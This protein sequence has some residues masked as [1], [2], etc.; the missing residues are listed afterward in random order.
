MEIAACVYAQLALG[1][2]YLRR[3]RYMQPPGCAYF[4]CG[5]ICH[6][7]IALESNTFPFPFPMGVPT[8]GPRTNPVLLMGNTK[9]FA[10]RLKPGQDLY[11]EIQNFAIQGE[12]RA[13]F[14][15]TCVGSLA[16]A[17][18]RFAGNSG[19]TPLH[20]P[21][22]ITSLVGTVS[23]TGLHLHITLA[24]GNGETVGG[25]LMRES[26]IHTTAEIV[27]GTLENVTFTRTQ[28][29]Q[30]GYRELEITKR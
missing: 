12:I 9:F 6:S 25:H 19:G 29:A 17:Q 10:L 20:G 27:I 26:M 18:V 22:E 16:G 21:F 8:I 3:L 13:G 7:Q 5:S 11:A 4:R 2:T 24:N 14:I 1:C 23:P 28:D 30:T 15:A